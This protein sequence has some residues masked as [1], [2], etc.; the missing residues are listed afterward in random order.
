MK[1]HDDLV[2]PGFFKTG[3]N[4]RVKTIHEQH[5]EVDP[6]NYQSPD[7]PALLRDFLAKASMSEAGE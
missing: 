3:W 1:A 6:S 7:D 4:A 2:F 5:P